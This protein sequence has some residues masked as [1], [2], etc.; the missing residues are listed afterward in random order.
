ME[1]NGMEAGG[2]GGGSSAPSRHRRYSFLLHPVG[3]R[4]VAAEGVS[5]SDSGGR[6]GRSGFIVEQS[7][8]GGR[9]ARR[10]VRV[11]VGTTSPFRKYRRL[12]KRTLERVESEYGSLYGGPAVLSISFSLCLAHRAVTSGSSSSPKLAQ[13]NFRVNS[14]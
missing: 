11:W 9:G 14:I 4:R 8:G 2:G 7:D 10:R 6:D 13:I 3:T 1:K 12:D 5:L